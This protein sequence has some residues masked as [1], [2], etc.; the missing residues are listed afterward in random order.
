[1][2]KSVLLLVALCFNYLCFSQIIFEKGY[3]IDNQNQKTECYIKNQDWKSNPSKIDYKL[4]EEGDPMTLTVSEVTEF[5]IYNS[6]KFVSTQVEI[7]RTLNEVSLLTTNKNPVFNEET[8]FLKVLVEG[9]KSLYEYIQGNITRYFYGTSAQDAKQL[10]WKSYK[11]DQDIIYENN[12]FR[13]QLWDDLKCPNFEIG[14]FLKLSYDKKD[15]IPLFVEYNKCNNQEVAYI[16]KHKNRGFFNL[17]LKPRWMSSSLEI[18]SSNQD[19]NVKFD[20]ESDFGFGLEVEYILGLNKNKWA[21]FIEGVYEHFDTEKTR[22]DTNAFFGAGGLTT[23]VSYKNISIPFGVRHY[24]FL[25]EKSKIFIDAAYVMNANFSSEVKYET[26]NNSDLS[27]ME[28]KSGSNLAFGF[29]YKFADKYSVGLN[30]QTRR[31]I[32]SSY[33]AHYTNLNFVSVS[34]GYTLF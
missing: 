5:T 1:M 6:S 30:Y 33:A 8:L 16:D 14:S 26:S 3:F 9:E 21:F 32:L 19:K 4:T 2:K 24:F 7:D 31:N 20:N 27:P 23:I 13:K 15:L 17:N 34:L 22:N 28:I 25:N 11:D 29:G 12:T 18:V 10:V